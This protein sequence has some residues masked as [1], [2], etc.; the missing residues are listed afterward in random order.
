[1]DIDNE[2]LEKVKAAAT[3]E[4]LATLLA[5]AGYE[6]APADVEELF[7]QVQGASGEGELSDDDLAAVNGGM[8]GV[9]TLALIFKRFAKHK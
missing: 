8:F 3:V 7:R 1:M 6:A 5:D 9:D 2:L 4:E